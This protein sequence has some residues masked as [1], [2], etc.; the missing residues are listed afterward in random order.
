MHLKIN[1]RFNFLFYIALII[2]LSSINNYNFYNK[3]PFKIKKLEVTGFSN[4]KNMVLKKEIKDIL[5][6][7]IIFIK[8]YYFKNLID[9]NDIK[10][11]K[12]KKI[13]PNKIKITLTPAKPICIIETNNNIVLLGDNGKLLD[14]KI[15]QYNLPIVSGSSNI[16][17][18]YKL[19][20]LLMISKYDY[21]KIKSIIFFKSGRFDLE[22]K[23]G[24][25]IRFPIKYSEQII[26]HSF[27]LSKDK[28]FANSKIIDLRIKNKI[29]NYE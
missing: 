11:L 17:D 28:R 9:R 27:K 13:Y 23:N 22:N 12:V 25:I 20:N 19:I 18:I 6:K 7:N 14:A 26:N 29:I 10:E 21:Q 1:K 16:N 2:I 5:G 3:N 24:T 4:E 15:E 8:K